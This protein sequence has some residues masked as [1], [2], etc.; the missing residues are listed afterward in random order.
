MNEINETTNSNKKYL[1]DILECQR[2][3]EYLEKISN[4]SLLLKECEE[5][6]LGNDI[7]NACIA[8]S[9]MEELI[10]LIPTDNPIL[11]SGL[12]Y[13]SIIKESKIIK[14]RFNSRLRRLLQDFIQISRGRIVVHKSLSGI[15]RSEN[16]LI[17]TELKLEDVW[18]ALVLVS[19]PNLE[20]IITKFLHDIWIHI[21]FPLWKEKKL[22]SPRIK[23][24]GEPSELVI[25]FTSSDSN[26]IEN[27]N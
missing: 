19:G 17:T 2:L 6:V 18:S 20:E 9:K 12:V 5:I 7:M 27:G 24:T 3:T 1:N 4:V 8:L 21:I 22:L 10:N 11:N 14:S 13:T 16:T 23:S 15:L 26:E 25:E